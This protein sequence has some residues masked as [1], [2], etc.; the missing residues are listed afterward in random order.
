MEPDYRQ[1][2]IL[3]RFLTKRGKIRPRTRSGLCSRHQRAIA[4]EIKRGRNLGLL[5]FRIVA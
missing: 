3:I 5:P 1:D 2:E 4:K